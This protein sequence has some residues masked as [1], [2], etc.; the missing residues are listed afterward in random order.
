MKLYNTFIYFN[1]LKRIRH[2]IYTRHNYGPC[3]NL[4]V[5]LHNIFFI[6]RLKNRRNLTSDGESESD[7]EEPSDQEVK[8]ST[9]ESDFSDL[10]E[11][12]WDGET[13]CYSTMDE[14]SDYDV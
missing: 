13:Q 14:M 4:T 3:V 2:F 9:E 10:D 5:I 6:F 11:L 7:S 12:N 8:N 1:V